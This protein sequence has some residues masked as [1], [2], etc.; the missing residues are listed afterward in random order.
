MTMCMLCRRSLL[1]G[2]QYRVW[3]PVSALGERPICRLCETEAA[4]TGWVCLDRPLEREIADGP[5]SH[6]R[7]VA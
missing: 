1:T 5:A 4:G 6:G 7:K 2:E 3:Q